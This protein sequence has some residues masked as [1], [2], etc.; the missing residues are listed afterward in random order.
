MSLPKAFKL[1]PTHCGHL[2]K[3]EGEGKYRCP[4]TDACAKA[5]CAC[6]P[7]Y[8]DQGKDLP[9]RDWYFVPPDKDGL[10]TPKA[11]SNWFDDYVC[12]CVEPVLPVPYHPKGR[13]SN[14]YQI[15]SKDDGQSVSCPKDDMNCGEGVCMLFRLR[16]NDRDASW[17]F[18]AKAGES[19]RYDDGYFYRC[20]CATAKW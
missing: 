19:Q 9:E 20:Y 10:V 1:N 8:S 7:F 13:C 2:E 12:I 3:A 14:K 15:V 5:R 11:G 18:A 6:E 16:K 17:E 4:Q